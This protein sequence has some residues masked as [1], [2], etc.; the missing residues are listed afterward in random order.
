MDQPTA[1]AVVVQT[2]IVFTTLIAIGVFAIKRVVLLHMIMR[3]SVTANN[4][5][6]G[7]YIT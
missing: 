1:E 4:S 6:G 7:S 2:V 5:I 3:P